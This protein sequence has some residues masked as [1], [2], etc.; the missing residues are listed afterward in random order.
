[1]AGGGGREVVYCLAT[2]SI[3][4]MRSSST[5]GSSVLVVTPD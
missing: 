1:M 2:N 5:L 4:V 3:C